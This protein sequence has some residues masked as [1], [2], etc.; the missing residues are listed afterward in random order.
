M[1]PLASRR[2]LIIVICICGV[3]IVGLLKIICPPSEHVVLQREWMANAEYVGDIWTS[4]IGREN[5][6]NLDVKEGSELRDPIKMVRSG[7]AQFGVASADRILEENEGGAGLLIIAS[8]TYK[9]PVVF[10]SKKETGIQSPNSFIGKTIGIQVGTNTELVFE[11]LIEATKVRKEE[12]RVVESGW[13]IQTF[14]SGDIDVLGAFD[15]DETIQL[16]MRSIEY[17]IIRPE[18]YGVD[19]VGTV[20]FTR[21][22]F[23]RE[24]PSVVQEFL[25]Y[26]VRGWESALNDPEAAMKML[27]KYKPEVDAI[28][29]GM[30][31]ARGKHYFQGENQRL[32]YSGRERWE[33][34][35]NSLI[36]MG[37]LRSFDYSS[38][39]DY[40][41]LEIAL[42][43][44][45]KHKH[46]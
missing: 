29:E 22:S 32:L 31:L 37:R 26:L 42:A 41:Y 35:T 23:A 15:Y 33:S 16:D 1:K 25:R 34:M 24:N 2:R 38:N 3:F 4:K 5:G 30:S 46:D 6:F 10:L 8:A 19:Y 18:D 17:D 45:E 20:Y 21:K 40:S 44:V 9:T 13:G 14:V 28:K 7:D 43:E 27:V 11:A 39:I 36:Q 12:L